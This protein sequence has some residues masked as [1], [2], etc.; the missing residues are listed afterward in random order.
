MTGMSNRSWGTFGIGLGLAVAL[1]ACTSSSNHTATGGTTSTTAGA[2]PTTGAPAT[3]TTS[4]TGS[5]TS[6]PVTAA[7]PSRCPTSSLTGS[8]TGASGTAGSTYYQLVL[9]N[10]GSTSCII[11]GYAGVSF[12]TGSSGRQL[13]APA[14]RSPGSAPSLLLAPG[15]RAQA[16]LHITDAVNYGPPCGIT[17]TDGLRVYPPDERASLL[18][19]HDDKGCSNTSDVTLHIG[20]FSASS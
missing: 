12:V 16:V 14:D 2:A 4:G 19:V 5:A 6:S 7:G 18:V 11:Q 8:L 13:G 3:P 1:S 15:H 10:T 9:T 20:P 17:A